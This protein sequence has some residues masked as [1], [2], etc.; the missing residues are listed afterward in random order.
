MYLDGAVNI[1]LYNNVLGF[2]AGETIAGTIDVE[3]GKPFEAVDL[4]VEFKGVERS[5]ITFDDAQTELK[6]YHR[7]AKELISMKQIIVQFPEGQR[8][9][10]GQY[11]YA[12]QIYTPTWLPE[13][14]LFKTLKNRFTVEY[15]LR[16]QFTPR[17]PQN[18]VDHPALAGMH[19]NVSLFRGS[20]KI[21]IYQAP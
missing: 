10:P 13:S 2:A 7:E 21:Y 4:V 20:R 5:H 17:D 9:E 14:T 6:P 15:T 19:W 18:Y 16:A 3:I 11:S 8:L 12:F 1:N